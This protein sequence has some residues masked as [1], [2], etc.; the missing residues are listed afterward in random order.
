MQ[1]GNN[2]QILDLLGRGSSV[3]TN[4]V[5]SKEEYFFD[6]YARSNQTTHILKISQKT[7]VYLCQ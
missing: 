4:F 6:G 5:L 2:Y 7:L 1:R 3:S